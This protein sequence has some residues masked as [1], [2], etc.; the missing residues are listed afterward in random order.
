MGMHEEYLNKLKTNRGNIKT[1]F[2]EYVSFILL[3]KYGHNCSPVQCA[4]K[5]KNN[6]QNLRLKKK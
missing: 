3:S 4:T 2:W 1:G 6:S 5:H